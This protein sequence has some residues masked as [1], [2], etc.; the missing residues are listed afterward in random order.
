MILIAA[1]TIL[2]YRQTGQMDIRIGIIVANRGR[3]QT[4]GVIGHFINTL[5]LRTTVSSN[6]TYRNILMRVKEASLAAYAH[7]ELS[8]E[9]L[10]TLLEEEQKV[11]R[12]TLFN[13]L[14]NYQSRSL[15]IVEIAGLTFAPIHW[16]QTGAGQNVMFTTFDLVLNLRES[17]TKLTGTVNYDADIFDDYNIT[18]MMESLYQILQCIIHEPAQPIANTTIGARA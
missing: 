12:W 5:I 9:H 2:L 8:F 16:K 13:V 6:M 11:D 15:D 3:K 1:L 10:A 14:V 7:Q 4:D 17:S 18:G